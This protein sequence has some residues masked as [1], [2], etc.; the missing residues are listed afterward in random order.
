MGEAARM[1]EAGVK[2]GTSIN[3]GRPFGLR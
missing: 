1:E 3:E 2:K